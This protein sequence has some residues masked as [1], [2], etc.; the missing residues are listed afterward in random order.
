VPPDALV[1]VPGSGA[2]PLSYNI[3]SNQEVVLRAAFASFNGAAAASN[4]RPCLRIL[5]PSGQVVGQYITDDSVSAGGSADVSFFPSAQAGGAAVAASAVQACRLQLV[6]DFVVTCGDPGTVIVWSGAVFDTGSPSP[7]WNP[8]HP[9]R[10]TAPV[11]GYYLSFFHPIW[12]MWDPGTLDQYSQEASY[13]YKNTETVTFTGSFMK[14]NTYPVAQ[15]DF[16]W[17]GHAHGLFHLTAGDYLIINAYVNQGFTGPATLALL[18]LR[19]HVGQP[20]LYTA[21]DLIMLAA[22]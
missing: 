8:A 5:S 10:M 1:T 13:L 21:W 7:F 20:P 17:S 14:E 9:K 15:K 19:T 2:A 18:D 16:T 6:N 11:D 22:T 12:D 4:F 3:G